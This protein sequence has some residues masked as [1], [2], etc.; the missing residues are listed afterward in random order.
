[1]IDRGFHS[2]DRTRTV[3]NNE[4]YDLEPEVNINLQKSQLWLARRGVVKKQLT[5]LPAS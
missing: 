5:T 3:N 2:L 4:G 1:M